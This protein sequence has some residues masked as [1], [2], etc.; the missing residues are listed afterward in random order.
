MWYNAYEVTFL[1][2][3]MP[4]N[5]GEKQD[6][7]LFDPLNPL[8][9][10]SGNPPQK[11]AWEPPIVSLNLE[12]PKE[13]LGGWMLDKIMEQVDAPVPQTVEDIIVSSFDDIVKILVSKNYDYAKVTPSETDVEITFV[14]EAREVEKKFIKFPLY[15]QIT[16]QVKTLS[17]CDLSVMNKVQEGKGEHKME[18]KIYTINLKTQ[19]GS[20]GEILFIKSKIQEIKAK[21]KVSIGQLLSFLWATSFVA[22]VLGGGFITFVVLNANTI[23]DVQFFYSL[24]ISLNDI[25]AFISKLVLIIFSILLFIE[26][27][28]LAI[29]LFK[30]WLTKKFEKR[31]KVLYGILSIILFT[32]TFSTGSAWMYLDAKVK[33]LP[34]W[35]EVA[36]GD[37]QIFDND[38]LI[39]ESFDKWGALIKDTSTLIW[40]I[41]LKYDLSLFE[42]KEEKNGYKVQKY[43]WNFG[44]GE[45]EELSPTIIKKLDKKGT[46]NVTLVVEEIDLT[47]KTIE[48][49]VD[50][51]WD[52]SITHIVNVKETVLKNGGKQ[53]EFDASDLK[54]LWK[55]EWYF[56]DDLENPVWS[57]SIF[58]PQK[59]FYE[60]DLIGM[61]IKT[62]W[63]ED[64]TFDKI[65]VIW[66]DGESSINGTIEAEPSIENELSYTFRVKDIQNDFGEWF[67]QEFTWVFNDKTQV[68]KANPLDL[69]KSS[70]IKYEFT[71]YGKHEVKVL[72]KDSAGNIKEIKTTINI[73]KLVKLKEWI[74]I[75]DELNSTIDTR[76]EA[77][78][79]E[80][81]INDLGIPSKVKFDAR[82]VRSDNIIYTLE[83]ITWDIGSDGTLEGE[84]KLF[85][86]DI[87][88]EWNFMVLVTYTFQ[89]RKI[90][91][92]QV[93][94]T[95]KVYIE[96]VRKE[97]IVD[98]K[99]E[100][101]SN[102]APVMVRFDASLSSVKDDNIIKFI[103]DYGDGIIDERGEAIVGGHMYG[104]AWEYTIK[105]TVL[106]EKG[107][108]YSTSKKLVLSPKPQ[109]AEIDV[110]MKT[111]PI[112]QG[113]DFSS[114]K[115]EGQI[116][117]YF[118]DFGDGNTSI[119]ANPTHAY[120]KVGSYDVL[121]RV[122][123]G[124]NNYQEDRL[125]ITV[126]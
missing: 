69:E 54:D 12:T 41:T 50:D 29:S 60:E 26:F 40:P 62:E 82:N 47:G 57:G 4:E 42:Q 121:L 73:S 56:K 110:S 112:W 44:D 74:R 20:S 71:S 95:E 72:L 122:G 30:W 92:E 31:K 102:Y 76:Y 7:W 96:A 106:T 120:K 80:Y 61:L 66:G 15:T 100:K 65:F 98:F 125:T 3:F 81:F 89:H 2:A 59:V 103:Y 38:K 11:A 39:S 52:I 35:Q 67:V 46:Y 116:V 93:N 97:A 105:L 24:W 6:N 123:Y 78:G 1:N 87:Q 88:K 34:N 21:K 109:V 101:T 124:N 91:T 126:E 113:I 5:T 99:I 43:K 111:A 77:K 79:N 83:K 33:A 17:S 85:E 58:R 70:E 51:I 49:K 55:V 108:K 32:V 37:V 28:V 9:W 18:W 13:S 68:V 48:K 10:V 107:K 8:E 22:F 117:S 119:E 53:M 27:I 114:D 94:L 14:K 84:G 16:L 19:P 115:S 36:Y 86:Y 25:N 118:W 75:T 90:P 45:V 104:K 63:E 64:G 23:D